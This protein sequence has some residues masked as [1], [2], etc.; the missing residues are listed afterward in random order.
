MTNTKN[1]PIE[2]LERAFPV[3]V[4]RSRLR[5]ASGGVGSAPGGEGIERDL[6]MPEDVKVSLITERRVSQPR[7]L[8]GGELGA[9]GENRLLP[10]GDESQAERLR[11]KCTIWMRTGDVLR[12]LT[13]GGGGWGAPER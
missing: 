10:S 5:R 2:A 13:P 7:G 4:L 9:V 8:A 11:D 3:R 6:Q 12:M 1:A